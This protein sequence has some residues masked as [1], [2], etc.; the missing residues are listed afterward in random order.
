[1]NVFP[2]SIFQAIQNAGGPSLMCLHLRRCLGLTSVIGVQGT[3]ELQWQS[4]GTTSRLWAFKLPQ[5]AC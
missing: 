1:M 3:V 2:Y 5:A 4:R